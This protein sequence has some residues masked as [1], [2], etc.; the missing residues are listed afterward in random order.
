MCLDGAV[1]LEAPQSSRTAIANATYIPVT[2]VISGP[3]ML[4]LWSR[5]QETMQGE[6]GMSSQNDGFHSV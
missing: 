1:G 2:G 6:N 5:T 4:T 3:K